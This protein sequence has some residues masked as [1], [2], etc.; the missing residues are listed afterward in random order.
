MHNMTCSPNTW[1]FMLDFTRKVGDDD[2]G[3]DH[4]YCTNTEK[5]QNRAVKIDPKVRTVASRMSLG[6]RDNRKRL[7][8]ETVKGCAK[9]SFSMS[10]VYPAVLKEMSRRTRKLKELL[11]ISISI[12]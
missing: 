12:F 11:L 4:V 6:F 10:E 3:N 5:V 1:I 9:D 2:F 7:V 8:A